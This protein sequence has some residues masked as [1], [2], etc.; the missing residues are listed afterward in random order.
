MRDRTCWDVCHLEITEGRKRG[1]ADADLRIN[2]FYLG[3]FLQ[4]SPLHL[5]PPFPIHSE[6]SLFLNGALCL[7]VLEL[8]EAGCRSRLRDLYNMAW[9]GMVMVVISSHG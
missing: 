4:D 6:T 2:I 1:V 7:S 5:L 3:S 9:F 8:G